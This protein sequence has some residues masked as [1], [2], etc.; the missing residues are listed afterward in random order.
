ML[1]WG[2]VNAEIEN[3]IAFYGSQDEELSYVDGL[4]A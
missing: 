2:S 4:W 3:V 1:I